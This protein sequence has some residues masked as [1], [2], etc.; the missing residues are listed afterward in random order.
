MQQYTVTVKQRER[1]FAHVLGLIV[2]LDAVSEWE[3]AER[4][5]SGAD[6]MEVFYGCA[7]LHHYEDIRDVFNALPGDPCQDFIAYWNKIAPLKPRDEVEQSDDRELMCEPSYELDHHWEEQQAL[8][9]D[10]I[11]VPP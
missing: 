3:E 1:V 11:E 9:R 7:T 4:P 8:N 2:Y 10:R 5:L 6:A